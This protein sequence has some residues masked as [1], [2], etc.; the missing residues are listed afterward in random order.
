[1][2]TSST[3]TKEQAR[4]LLIKYARSQQGILPIYDANI[5]IR[6]DVHGQF[7]I[8]EYTFRYLLK[9]AYDLTDIKLTGL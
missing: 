4:E 6:D 8:S 7:V 3:I 1:M 5:Q 9:V 2:N